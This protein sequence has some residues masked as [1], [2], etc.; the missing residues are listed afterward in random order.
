M[1]IFS[2]DMRKHVGPLTE[3]LSN[4]S[5]FVGLCGLRLSGEGT[6]F[7]MDISARIADIHSARYQ[8]NMEFLPGV[9]TRTTGATCVACWGV[10]LF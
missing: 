1:F 8:I 10:C 4:Q 3:I 5:V 9:L 2:S 6:G 7:D